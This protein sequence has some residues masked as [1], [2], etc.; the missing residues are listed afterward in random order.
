MS[1]NE[2]FLIKDAVLLWET[3]SALIVNP[4]YCKISLAGTSMSNVYHITLARLSSSK[5]SS[6]K[7]SSLLYE[8]PKEEDAFDFSIKIIHDDYEYKNEITHLS[9]IANNANI[10][11]FYFYG[12]Y[13]EKN[14]LKINVKKKKLVKTKFPGLAS[15]KRKCYWYNNLIHEYDGGAII[16]KSGY[17]NL[18][19]YIE[20]D[21]LRDNNEF[22]NTIL[23]P[24]I[25]KWLIAAHSSNIVHRDIRLHNK[26]W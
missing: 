7:S 23:F 1:N 22:W 9:T 14:D 11:D 4:F 12:F 13:D 17:I 19:A 26:R 10:E 6:S 15:D 3:L 2:I 8:F 24:Q 18:K 25:T 21:S 5:S 16:M 20:G